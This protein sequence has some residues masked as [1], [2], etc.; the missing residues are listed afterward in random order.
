MFV[1]IVG[2]IF[3]AKSVHGVFPSNLLAE[4]WIVYNAGGQH[5]EIVPLQDEKFVYL[6]PRTI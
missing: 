2:N 5:C 1:V 4:E 6:E 3:G